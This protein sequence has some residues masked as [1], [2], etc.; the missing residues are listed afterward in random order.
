M[1]LMKT[2]RINELRESTNYYIQFRFFLSCLVNF[3]L[4]HKWFAP[5][6]IIQTQLEFRKLFKNNFPQQF[7]LAYAKCIRTYLFLAICFI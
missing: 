2:N 5:T 7:P 6:A 4:I 3:P 1:E